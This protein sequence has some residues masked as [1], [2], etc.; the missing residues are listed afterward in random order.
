MISVGGGGGGGIQGTHPADESRYAQSPQEK[1]DA[2]VI[3]GVGE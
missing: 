2:A 3:E 1:A